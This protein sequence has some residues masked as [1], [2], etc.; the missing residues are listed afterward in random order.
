MTRP[1]RQDVVAD[2]FEQQRGR[3][4]AIAYRMLGSRAD[5]EDAVQEAWLRLARQDT[6][7]IENLTAWLTTVVGR[8][9]VDMLRSRN[10][11]PEVPYEERL[12]EIVVTEDAEPEEDS[13]LAESVGLALLVVLDTLRPAERLAFVLHDMF[14]VPFDEIARI[15]G[16]SADATKM[17]ASRARRKVRDTHRPTDGPRRQRAV[18]DA[19]LDAARKGDF[20]GLLEV[21]DPD[22]AWRGHTPR[23]VVVRQGATA[24]AS[25]VQRGAYAK[26]TARPAL[27][28]GE[29]GVI[30]WDSNGSPMAVMACTVSNGRIVDILSVTDP[31]RL[32]TLDLP[33]RPD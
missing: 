23:G 22:V 18:V 17:L 24:V 26:V 11:R 27:V 6:A 13:L 30:A 9:C 21:L 31:A 4:V 16:K 7:A 12:P 19:F 32:A 29:P 14:G 2:A 25:L 28:N 8:I 15:V 1:G 5:A 33:A 20:Q 10:T 3:L